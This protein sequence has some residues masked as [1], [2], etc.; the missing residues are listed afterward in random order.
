MKIMTI[1]VNHLTSMESFERGEYDLA[2]GKITDMSTFVSKKL[3]FKDTVVCIM[4][5]KH[6]LAKKK[7]IT[8]N[9][10]LTNKHI[11]VRA[12]NPHIPPVVE[13]E[14][15]K[16]GHRRD[17]QVS[18]PFIVPIFKL[19]EQSENLIATVIRSTTELYNTNHRYVIKDL[20]FKLPV[21]DLYLAWHQRYD[22]DQGHKWLRDRISD[23]CDQ[24]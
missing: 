11:A 24:L 14:L 20:P 5:H 21:I 19:I 1:S 4:N 7:K 23:M 17:I 22:N 2:I 3:L 8:L 13:Q 9:D 15:A 18:L 10:Y 16:L 12:D 6:P